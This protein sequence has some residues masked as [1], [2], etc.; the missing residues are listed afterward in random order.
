[1]QII[2]SYFLIYLRKLDQP[3]YLIATY[4]GLSVT[5][6]SLHKEGF[7]SFLNKGHLFYDAERYFHIA[8]SLY[9]SE[10]TYAFHPLWPLLLRPFTQLNMNLANVSV[11]V[12]LL[13]GFTFFFSLWPFT[14][15]L[16]QYIQ[17]WLLAPLC[18]LYV[19]APPSV[20]HALPFSESLSALLLTLLLLESSKE[21]P[22][23]LNLGIL[24]ILLC[25]TRPFVIFIPI[26]V[27][28]AFLLTEL[29]SSKFQNF[30]LLKSSIS[31]LISSLLGYSF[32]GAYCFSK[33]GNFFQPFEAQ[34]S[35]NR[36]F[37]FYWELIFSPK[38]VGGSAHVLFWDL[39]SFYGSIAF[40][41]L[42]IYIFLIKKVPMDKKFVFTFWWGTFLNVGHA[43]V[44]F[45][46]YPIFMSLSRHI[47]G[48]PTFFFSLAVVLNYFMKE[49]SRKSKWILYFFCAL[50]VFY[51][52][53]WWWRFARGSW[54]G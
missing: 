38:S 24:S 7:S 27:I 29:N 36:V 8:L 42:G 51:F 35:W 52:I 40:V 46:S 44:A 12:S 21:N 3:L 9:T 48:L 2:K 50:S 22:K 10:D 5:A 33:T 41:F 15:L 23:K 53:K 16:R 26:A 28:L 43:A 11:L 14:R 6:L 49:T 18:I 54:I 34:K 20:F 37:G 25:L 4:L 39:V 13:A 47:L 17:P 30:S 31:M 45:L 32:Y 1:M 19:F